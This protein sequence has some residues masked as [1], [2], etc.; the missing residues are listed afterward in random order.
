MTTTPEGDNTMSTMREHM[1]IP[2]SHE[3]PG[4][5]EC[6]CGADWDYWSDECVGA[7][8]EVTP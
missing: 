7:A 5:P 4:G 2:G 8:K 1:M 3:R 6:R